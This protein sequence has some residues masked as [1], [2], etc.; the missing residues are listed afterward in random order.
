[1]NIRK[2]ARQVWERKSLPPLWMWRP[3]WLR[4]L[5][6]LLWIPPLM[7]LALFALCLGLL[8]DALREAREWPPD[9]MAYVADTWHGRNRFF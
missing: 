7:L 5:G 6:L 9:F 3:A 2:F 4:R 1:M 8:L